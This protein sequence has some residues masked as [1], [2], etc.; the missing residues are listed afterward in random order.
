MKRERIPI[1][2]GDLVRCP[3][4]PTAGWHR[5]VR[6]GRRRD[7]T[8]YVTIRRGRIWRV[9]GLPAMQ[10]IEWSMLRALGYGIKKSNVAIEDPGA[11]VSSWARLRAYD[12]PNPPRQP[13]EKSDA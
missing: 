10:R 2:P 4:R 7:G 13:Q 5:V 9:L 6:V 3:D 8:R 1:R 12:W 11:I